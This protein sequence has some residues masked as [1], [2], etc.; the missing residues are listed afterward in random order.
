MIEEKAYLEERIDSVRSHK[1]VRDTLFDESTHADCP[2]MVKIKVPD[3]LSG[4][5]VIDAGDCLGAYISQAAKQRRCA[6]RD[7]P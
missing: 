2:K 5:P 4:M 1:P 3:M 6:M 7:L